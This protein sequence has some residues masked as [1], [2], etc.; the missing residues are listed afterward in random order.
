[1]VLLLIGNLLQATIP[2]SNGTSQL[3]DLTLIFQGAT[4]LLLATGVIGVFKMYG[5]QKIIKT[6][7]AAFEKRVAELKNE[8]DKEHLDLKETM[9]KDVARV[10]AD[11]VRITADVATIMARIAMHT[12]GH[13][14][15]RDWN[16]I[17]KTIEET[18]NQ[19]NTMM[20]DIK[21]LMNSSQCQFQTKNMEP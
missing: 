1:M 19:V 2:A 20:A 16:F 3:L 6:D 15:T 4:V 12:D 8:A 17:M 5:E 14:R 11:V 10:N 18:R 13:I 7:L 21:L 9:E